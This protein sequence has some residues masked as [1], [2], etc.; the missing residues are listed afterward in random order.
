MRDAFAPE[1]YH[2]ALY[3]HMYRIVPLLEQID[4][5]L[6]TAVAKDATDP[7]I[8]QLKTMS[9]ISL[10]GLFDFE[11]YAATY[12]D[13]PAANEFSALEHYVKLGEAEGRKPNVAF[14][15]FYYRTQAMAGAPVGQSAL[16]HYGEAGERQGQKPSLGFDPHAYLEANPALAAFVDRPLFHFLKLGLAAGLAVRPSP[17]KQREHAANLDYPLDPSDRA[18]WREL[19]H[20]LQRL[21][22]SPTPRSAGRNLVMGLAINYRKRELA[23]FVRSLRGCGYKDEI[24]LLVSDLDTETREFLQEHKVNYEY[25]WEMNFVPFDFMLARNF[26]YYRYLC[27]MRN[28]NQ[29]FDRILLTDVGDVVFQGDPFVTAP[30]GELTVYLEDKVRTLDTC[31][32]CGYWIRSAFSDSAFDELRG[33]RMSCAG[34]VL[35]TW[36]GI[37]RYLLVMQS[38][39]FECA[40]SARKLEGIDQA[41]HNVMLY[42]DRLAGAVVIENS[43]HVFTMG[44][45]P[46]SNIVITPDGMITDGEGRVCP[47]IHQYNRHP[48]VTKFV[49]ERYGCE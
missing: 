3:R 9:S 43:E 19:N 11:F 15:P 34:T 12:R 47:V 20:Q 37:L 48:A 36:T 16:Q 29:A 32:V 41:I 14:S 38:G 21:E 4:T 6:E 35:G 27:A 25:Y 46:K 45:V 24:V 18:H 10:L 42:R 26:S 28:L 33:R 5:E 30:A 1:A 13:V 2:K 7:T 40:V 22:E 39:A 44:I 23:P 31:Y 8:A 49:R 17:A